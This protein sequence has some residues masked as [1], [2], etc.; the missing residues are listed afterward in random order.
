MKVFL[1]FIAA[2][3]AP[4]LF[5]LGV[6]AHPGNERSVAYL[7]EQIAR[8]PQRYQ[9]Y[10]QRA[11][12]NIELENYELARLDLNRVE[13]LADQAESGYQRGQLSMRLG[14]AELA[15]KGYSQYLDVYPRFLPA[16][17][18]RARAYQSLGDK[19]RALQ[20]W[21]RL[22]LL[23]DRANPGQYVAAAR[24]ALELDGARAALATLDQGMQ[25]LGV[26]V[27][28]Q[29]LAINIC[30]SEGDLGAAIERQWQLRSVMQA[31]ALWY[32]QAGELLVLAARYSEAETMLTELGKQLEQKKP[33]PALQRFQQQAS[34]LR[35]RIPSESI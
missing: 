24:L 21:Q 18:A 10:L 15:V 1:R 29:R 5:A 2:L 11:G 34:L 17:E 20:D 13:L 26:I 6:S 28:L 35:Q 32:L 31:S 14:D 27:P 22:L 3:V 7:T 25:D 23:S 30:Q 33:S 8:Y 19:R 16:L 9:L 12:L 4:L